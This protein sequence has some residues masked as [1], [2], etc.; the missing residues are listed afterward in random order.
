MIK[1]CIFDVF[2]T[3][4]DWRTSVAREVAKVLPQIDAT[5][6]ATAW[7]A[8]YDPA[9]ARIRDG[10]RGYVPLD[11]LH[12][13]NMHRVAERFGV[14]A[15]EALNSA[16]ETLDPWPDVVPG[17]TA[18]KDT[19]IIAPCSNGSIALMTRL[20]RYGALPWDCILGAEIADRKSVV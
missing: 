8:E 19:H 4:V 7:R 14:T 3:C 20:A 16:W 5:A 10:G 1:A 17:L 15:P 12:R 2:G 13:E 18:L 6:F 11:D 9:M